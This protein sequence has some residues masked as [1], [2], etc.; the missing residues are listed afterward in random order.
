MPHS[1][2]RASLSPWEPALTQLR[3]LSPDRLDERVIRWLRSLGLRPGRGPH[4]NVR[5]TTYE[6]SLTQAPFQL[7]VHVRVYQR[8]NRLQ[9]HHV[10]AFLGSLVR[11]G[12]TA[13][14]LVT[15]G[16]FSRDAHRVAAQTQVPRVQLLGGPEWLA[17]QAAK[18]LGVRRC[19]IPAWLLR[20]AERK[21]SDLNVR[22]RGPR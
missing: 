15:T 3:E 14:V 4:R 9:A 18:R 21:V 19:S 7:P 1:V 10:E 13:G 20:L 17:D 11:Q 22:E 12:V 6:A 8:K 2:F 5:C 16:D